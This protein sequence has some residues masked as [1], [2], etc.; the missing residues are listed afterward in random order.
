MDAVKEIKVAVHANLNVP[1][2]LSDILD[3]VLEPALKDA[4][5]STG[6]SLDDIAVAALL[7]ILDSEVKSRVKAAWESLFA[8]TAAVGEPV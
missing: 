1:G 4:V 3:K 8:D 6:T 7:P 5:A 2:F